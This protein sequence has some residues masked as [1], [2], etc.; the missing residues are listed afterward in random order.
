MSWGS[1]ASSSSSQAAS[2]PLS[3]RS[4]GSRSS[5]TAPRPPSTSKRSDPLGR[6]REPGARV[7]EG[8]TAGERCARPAPRRPSPHL[9]HPPAGPTARAPRPGGRSG[10]KGL[11]PQPHGGAAWGLGEPGAEGPGYPP[12]APHANEHMSVVPR[13]PGVRGAGTWL[14]SARAQTPRSARDGHPGASASA[15]QGRDSG[16][17]REPRNARTR[18]LAQERFRPRGGGGGHVSLDGR[19]ENPGW[20]ERKP[21]PRLQLPQR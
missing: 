20:E 13:E 19:G 11:F 14:S 12:V 15:Q 9:P 21:G 2:S 8:S 3:D 7:G 4:G 1:S 18:A 17:P 5:S 10:R 6:Q 16:T